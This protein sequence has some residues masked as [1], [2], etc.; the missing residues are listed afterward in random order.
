M[1]CGLSIPAAQ[2]VKQPPR[3][4]RG[5]LRHRAARPCFLAGFRSALALICG[6]GTGSAINKEQLINYLSALFT[7]AKTTQRNDVKMGGKKLRVNTKAIQKSTPWNTLG[8]EVL[9]RRAVRAVESDS[10]VLLR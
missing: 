7:E 4:L 8:A 2:P 3:G 5:V 6:D 10:P 9:R 1:G